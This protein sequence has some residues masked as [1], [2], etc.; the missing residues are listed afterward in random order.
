MVSTIEILGEW[1]RSDGNLDITDQK[2]LTSGLEQMTD[3]WENNEAEY[4][5]FESTDFI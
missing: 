2:P 4:A 3:G 5:K 1:P